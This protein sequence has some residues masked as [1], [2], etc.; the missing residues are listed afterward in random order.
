MTFSVGFAFF[1]VVGSSEETRL[2]WVSTVVAPVAEGWFEVVVG[3]ITELAP[4]EGWTL[5]LLPG[6][7]ELE[8]MVRSD[9]WFDGFDGFVL[10]CWAS[11]DVSML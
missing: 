2:P 8:D 5:L 4:A 3:S 11:D 9:R 7:E 1:R 6:T 10:G